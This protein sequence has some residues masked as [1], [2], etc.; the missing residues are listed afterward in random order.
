[1][2]EYSC[3]YVPRNKVWFQALSP[4][5]QDTWNIIQKDRIHGSYHRRPNQRQ[6]N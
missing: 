3:I 6:K 1:M 5:I 2:D 4:K